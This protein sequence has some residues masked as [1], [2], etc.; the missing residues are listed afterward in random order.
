[1]TLL[2]RFTKPGLFPQRKDAKNWVLR[3][4]K[5]LPTGTVTPGLQM[6]K[7]STVVNLNAVRSHDH[8]RPGKREVDFPEST[9]LITSKSET[10][11]SYFPASCCFWCLGLVHHW[12]EYP[13]SF[14]L[15]LQIPWT[16]LLGWVRHSCGLRTSLLWG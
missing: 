9:Q 14:V 11:V 5:W 16:L 8:H 7:N 10:K 13:A 15:S 1:M 6:L 4:L 2:N 3:T 12:I